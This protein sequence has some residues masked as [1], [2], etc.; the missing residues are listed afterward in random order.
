MQIMQAKRS[1]K[2]VP[3]PGSGI[4]RIA[5][6]GTGLLGAS[7]GLA[8][9]ASGF[10][11]AI[12]G[13]DPDAASL[14]KA[15]AL[16][17]VDPVIA[18]EAD[19]DPFVC[20][21]AANVIVLAGPVFSIAEWLEKL[22]PVLSAAQLVTDLGSV[23]GFLVERVA[24]LYNNAGQPGWLPGH[25]MAGKEQ[26]G[27][28]FAEAGLFT[29]AAWLFTGACSAQDA[30][31]PVHPLRADWQHWVEQFGARVYTLAP[32]RHDVVCASVSHLPQMLATAFAASLEQQ[33][34]AGSDEERALVENIGGRA[35]REMTRLGASPY[36]MWRDIAMANDKA[37]AASLFALEQEMAHLR[38]N[39]RTPELRSLFSLANNFRSSLVART[40]GEEQ[41]NSV[42]KKTADKNGHG[43]QKR[44]KE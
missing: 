11:G 16:G 21:M 5:I 9:R 39:L 3:E 42:E 29:G 7:V 19:A 28:A 34:A 2:V 22:A 37:I 13:W 20:A 14:E 12:L 10:K 6:F 33:C 8:L 1:A 44:R 38:E 18:G 40:A 4:R 27:P 30:T 43:A 32:H 31:L 25:P 17:A 26:S 23:K 36:S 41:G 35:L 24:G 15:R